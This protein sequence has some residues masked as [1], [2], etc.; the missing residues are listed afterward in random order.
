[1]D[2]GTCTEST[3]AEATVEVH[4]VVVGTF[5]AALRPDTVLVGIA[6]TN[7]KDLFPT[8]FQAKGELVLGEGVGAEVAS[9][10]DSVGFGKEE[11]VGGCDAQLGGQ[12]EVV[13]TLHHGELLVAVLVHEHFKEIPSPENF[14]VGP[15]FFKVIPKWMLS[16][17]PVTY[18][19]PASMATPTPLISLMDSLMIFRLKPPLMLL[20]NDLANDTL[21]FIRLGL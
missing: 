1:M 5:N 14:M 11:V 20:E 16:N 21:M 3:G 12:F 13:D 18:W 17:G 2:S 8:I 10:S 4:A 15:M 9:H 7:H 6:S 19:I